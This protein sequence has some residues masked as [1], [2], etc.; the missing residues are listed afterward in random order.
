M[1]KTYKL[2]LDEIEQ[3]KK[4]KP[5]QGEAVTFW[6]RVAIRRGIDYMTTLGKIDEPYTFTGLELGHGKHWCWPQ[7]LKCPKLP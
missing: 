6:K 7:P 1:R 4:L 2:D 5:Y 3:F